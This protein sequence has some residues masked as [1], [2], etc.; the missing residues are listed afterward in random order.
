[1]AQAANQ[2]IY[3]V[4]G[5]GGVG[6][7]AVAAAL[8]LKKSRAGLKT[9]LVELGDQSFYRDYFNLEEVSYQPRPLRPQLDVALWSGPEALK[10]YARYLLKV[11][12]LYRL[13]FENNASRALINVAPA[14]SELAILGKVTSH[15]RHVGPPLAYDCLVVD[16]FAT[17]HFLALLKAPQGMA[18]AVRFGPMGEQSRSIN[19]FMRDAEVSSYYVVSF[20]EELPVI[21]GMELYSAIEG[22]TGLK[23]QHILNKVVGP[24]QEALAVTEPSLESFRQYLLQIHQVENE[25][26]Q[27]LQTQGSV[28]NLPQV[29]SVAAWDVVEKLAEVLP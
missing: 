15:H 12:S 17:G 2:K 9:L 4:T 22:L 24:T 25:L 19:K 29:F 13:F 18:E 5:K 6:K 14:L 8:A 26:R 21:E 3:Y 28:L 23:P 1:M 7:S 27:K 20:A 11:E 10:E 16:A